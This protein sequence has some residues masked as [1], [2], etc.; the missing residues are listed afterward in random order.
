MGTHRLKS[1]S[2]LCQCDG[3]Q[4]HEALGR[5]EDIGFFAQLKGFFSSLEH[6]F[7]QDPRASHF[8]MD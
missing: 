5:A 1:C 6:F 2:Q 4:L 3:G 8:H 7:V